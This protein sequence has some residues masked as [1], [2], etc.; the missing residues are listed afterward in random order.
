MRLLVHKQQIQQLKSIQSNT[1][2]QY[3]DDDGDESSDNNSNGMSERR[4][5]CKCGKDQPLAIVDH[6]YLY[7]CHRCGM[8]SHYQCM[9]QYFTS[10]NNSK[11]S[12]NINMLCFICETIDNVKYD[13]YGDV[14]ATTTTTLWHYANST[15]PPPSS[16][17]L[18][19]STCTV[20][21]RKRRSTTNQVSSI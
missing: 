4:L 8:F 19:T 14:D 1:H 6:A 3:Y 12:K 9:P 15:P 16:S 13:D 17:S 2:H 5:R 7:S 10:F 18:S 11:I 21:N 20:I